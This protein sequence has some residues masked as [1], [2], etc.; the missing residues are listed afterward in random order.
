[1]PRPLRVLMTSDTLGG[2]FSYSV[3]LCRALRE[4]G[5]EVMLMTEGARLQADQKRELDSIPGLVVCESSL[6]VEW[7]DDPWE[8]VERAGALLLALEQDFTPDVVH[9]NGYSHAALPFRASALIVAHSSVPSWWRAVHGEDAPVRY[10]EYRRRVRAGFAAARHVVAPTRSMLRALAEHDGFVGEASI[11]PNGAEPGLYQVHSKESFVLAAG[12][13][14]DKAKNLVLIDA[15]ASCLSWPVRVAGDA[16]RPDAPSQ[17]ELL[18]RLSSEELRALLACAPIFVHPARYEPFG[19]A[20]LEAALS[21]CALVLGDIASLREIWGDAAIYVNPD[22]CAG[23][24][25]KVEELISDSEQVQERG[26]KARERALT[27]G[28][29]PMVSAY[30]GVYRELARTRH[31]CLAGIPS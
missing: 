4:R 13:L 5:V 7:M 2:V 23:L 22:D 8:D 9:V 6:S 31:A 29:T 27:Y 16:A 14:W 10:A 20:P 17:C 28:V 1:M 3:T 18:G 24:V 19:L 12:R 21:G 15:A 30:L 26:R 25:A 11:I